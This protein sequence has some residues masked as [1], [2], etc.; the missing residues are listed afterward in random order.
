M[1]ATW[2]IGE[3]FELLG[4]FTMAATDMGSSEDSMLNQWGTV[5]ANAF[6][7]GAVVREVL[8]D[9]DRLGILAGQPLRVT[10]AEARLSVPVS[11]DEDENVTQD[12]ERVD[13][14]PSGREIDIQIAYDTPLLP[15]M[16][17][18]S[19]L[20]LQLEPGHDAEAGPAYGGGM[21]FR[22]SF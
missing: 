16:A 21:K 8:R 4:S 11:M 19:W 17:L 7:A 20:M 3:T 1:G 12:S 9:G 22:M 6:G 14:T 13:I 18:S 15:G 2:P 10:K 5:Q